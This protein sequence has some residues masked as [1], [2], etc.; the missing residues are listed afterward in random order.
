M[1]RKFNDWFRTHDYTIEDLVK[2][3]QKWYEIDKEDIEIVLCAI[4]DREIVPDVKL[5]FVV[6]NNSGGMKSEF[7]KILKDCNFIYTLDTLTPNTLVSGKVYKDKETGELIPVKG[8]LTKMDGKVLL[9]KDGSMILTL[10]QDKRREIFGQLRTLADGYI[11]RGY[12]NLPDKVRVEGHI[13]FIMFSTPWIDDFTTLQALLGT[14]FLRHR[15]RFKVKAVMRKI[16]LNFNK[17][18]N[19]R[20]DLGFVVQ[21]FLAK[22]FNEVLLP[23]VSDF[24]LKRIEDLALYVGKMRTQVKC[25]WWKG[26]IVAIVR[27]PSEEIPSRLYKQFIKLGMLLSLIRGKKE[28][29]EKEWDTLVRVGE[30]SITPYV[31][32]KI[33][34]RYL[35]NNYRFTTQEEIAEQLK[36]SRK[37][38]SVHLKLMEGCLLV[39]E[40]YEL[41]KET[42]ALMEKV[43][44]NPKLLEAIQSQ[45]I[46]PQ[47]VKG[48]IPIDKL[49][50]KR[51]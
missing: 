24:W 15:M 34:K 8:L 45:P 41:T 31:R 33:L 30:D 9:I 40:S 20:N 39:D 37:C 7:S 18:D 29:T 14:R 35:K 51:D 22:K 48:A 36:V 26:D 6:I 3:F 12:G 21:Y 10:H 16:R 46:R 28:F 50:P 27:E 13:G 4:C 5:W 38:V 17:E 43:Y 11:E 1:V 2:D 25:E 49:M 32:S 42:K 19:I 44:E 23:T 47:I